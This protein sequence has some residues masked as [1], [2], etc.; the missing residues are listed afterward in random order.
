MS[1]TLTPPVLWAQR[2]DSV[3]LKVDLKEV[4]EH[5]VECRGKTI[6]FKGYGYGA[7]GQNR[8]G[9]SL[10]LLEAVETPAAS[11][12]VTQRE[13][14]ITLRKAAPAWWARLTSAERR[15]NFVMPDFDRWM[16]ESDAEEEL[17]LEEMKNIG[18]VTVESRVRKHPLLH[19]HRGYLFV[20]NLVQ[21]LGFA[22]VLVSL[23]VPLLLGHEFWG[24]ALK[25]AHKVLRFC[26]V[27]ALLEVVHPLAGLV[28]AALIPTAL[29]VLGRGF[30]LF[31]VIGMHERLSATN[32]AFAVYYL[33]SA[34]EVFRYAPTPLLCPSPPDPLQPHAAGNALC[35]IKSKD[36]VKVLTFR[37]TAFE[38]AEAQ[39]GSATEEAAAS[40]PT[41][42]GVSQWLEQSLTKSDRPELTS[43][44]VVISGG[45]GLKNGENFKLLYDLADKMHAAV[46]A[47]R[48][49]VDAGFV[50][51]DLQVGQ[52]GKMVAPEL[53]I[54][55]GI[56][57][58]IQHLAGMKD[59]KTIVAINKD[60]EAPIFQVA[61][62]GIVADL[63]KVVPEMTALL[64]TK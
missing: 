32:A 19:V 57:G 4:S 61:D 33:W 49:A 14:A 52:T 36:K 50:P 44:K 13:V 58:A 28:S 38:A 24:S 40:A 54:A 23:Y 6:V 45:R 47:S 1:P 41:A 63:F 55:V 15:P 48:A 2:H 20:Y 27:L 35:T 39:G 3:S 30:M 46:G 18:K 11:V 22:Y 53:Y 8:Y 37:G 17:R 62:F 5:E 51:N 64:E 26:Q 29:Q 21:L 60:P 59:S 42:A 31:V 25:D 56:S 34:I 9:F 12:R 43:A 16:D 10:E 7:Q